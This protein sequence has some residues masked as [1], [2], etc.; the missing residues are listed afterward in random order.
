MSGSS[1]VFDSIYAH[2]YDRL[3]GT[4]E[5]K[6]LAQRRARALR[7]AS[8]ETLEIGAG[9]GFNLSHYPVAV[10]ELV[11]TE[12]SQGMRNELTKRISDLD[13]TARV[14][15]APAERLPFEDHSFDTV[16]ATLVLCTVHDP[17]L[18]VREVARVLRRG[19]R[20]LFLEHVR[21]A[22]PSHAAWQDR[23]AGPWKVIGRG[24]HANRDTLATIEASGLHIEQVERD[25]LSVGPPI[26]R[27][28]I[29]GVARLE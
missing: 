10:S 28:V 8:G 24:C 23:L 2:A 20:F 19:G 22:D 7:S 25:R 17:A 14:V 16:V 11:L 13:V 27:P 6:D 5:R 4:A 29:S 12:P 9:T 18:A 26:V 3:V 15:S 21:S 1:G